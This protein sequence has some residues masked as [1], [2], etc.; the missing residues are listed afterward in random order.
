MV[1]GS[2]M[3]MEVMIRMIR[4]RT[5]KG[6]DKDDSGI[7]EMKTVELVIRGLCCIVDDMKLSCNP[8]TRDRKEQFDDT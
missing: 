4:S 3:W 2:E 8:Q 6:G 5:E 7:A 1:G